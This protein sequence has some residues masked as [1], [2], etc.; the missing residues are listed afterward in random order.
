MKHVL[1]ALKDSVLLEDIVRVVLSFLRAAPEP[2][3]QP[4]SYVPAPLDDTK[5]FGTY[6]TDLVSLPSW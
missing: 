4:Q 6:E 5:D 3:V 1:E 2:Y